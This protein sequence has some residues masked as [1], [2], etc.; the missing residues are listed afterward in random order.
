MRLFK[1]N[2]AVMSESYG[3]LGVDPL[4]CRI[5]ETTIVVMG[6]MAKEK[7]MDDVEDGQSEERDE[8][9]MREV[10]QVK[11]FIVELA[12]YVPDVSTQKQQK[13]EFWPISSILLPICNSHISLLL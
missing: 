10:S 2:M 11:Q 9:Y 8:A 13:G 12:R 4:S 6:E 1:P 5:R 7:A 3:V